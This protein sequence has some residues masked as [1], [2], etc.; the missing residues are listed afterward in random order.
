[1]DQSISIIQQQ[2]HYPMVEPPQP[3]EAPAPEN[4]RHEQ[5]MQ[6]QLAI[7]EKMQESISA[8]QKAML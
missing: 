3:V 5:L 1:M 7:F 4:E 6:Q 8:Q 2:D